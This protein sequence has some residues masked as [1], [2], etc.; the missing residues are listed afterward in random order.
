LLVI[1]PA[2]V[3]AISFYFI[4]VLNIKIPFTSYPYLVIGVIAIIPLL[5]LSIKNPKIMSK[6]LFIGTYFFIYYF[7]FE[8]LAVYKSYWIYPG[9]NYIGWIQIL[10]LR[11]PFEE[12]FFWMMLYASTIV[13]YYELFIDDER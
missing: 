9:N 5:Y 1:I 10:N 7:V 3:L 8:M 13:S 4:A 11:F 6:F 2:L 12:M